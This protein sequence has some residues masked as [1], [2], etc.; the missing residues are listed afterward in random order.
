MKQN[1]INHIAL[2]IDRS[3]SM[4]N[5]ASDVVKVADSQIEYLAKRSKELDQETRI[6]VYTFADRVECLVYD[7][8]VLRMPSLK[9]MFRPDGMTALIDASAK[10]IE[11]LSK[12]PE[13]Y[14]DHA[15]LVYV[16]T[17]GGENASRNNRADDLS[18]KIKGLAD[19]WTVAV[20][21]PDQTG[22]FEAKKFG[23][24]GDN[25][26]VWDT[27]SKGLSEVGKAI[28]QTTDNFMQGRATGVRGTKNLFNMADV[29]K[30]DV[31]SALPK[32]HPGQYR[33]L[34]VKEEGPI[35]PFVEEKTRRAYKS[36]EAF[37]QLSK[38]EKV[39]PSKSVALRDK[40]TKEVYMGDSARQLLGLPD[41]EV[42]VAP[43]SH[44]DLEIYIQSTSVNRKL[45]P[46][47]NLLLIS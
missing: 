31:T 7:K 25:I 20:F 46:G 40:K 27:T 16:L 32:L 18:R 37:Y 12:T 21:V 35:A 44:P 36:G 11:D 8:D 39:Q 30:A 38:P 42:K 6:T 43:T 47:T 4:S 10:A 19:N 9:G 15:F 33:L 3:S 23:F 29:K 13:L 28:R 24:P 26:A 41:Y 17:D 14:G 2:V 45:V 34:Q 22:K 1:Y 5:L